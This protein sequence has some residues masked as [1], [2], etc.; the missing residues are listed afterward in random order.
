MFCAVCVL[1]TRLYDLKHLSFP[2]AR[3]SPSAMSSLT[4]FVQAV[5]LNV[6]SLVLLQVLLG[7][8][9]AQQAE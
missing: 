1:S 3:A 9:R 4:A 7:L 8:V 2:K 6:T 5:A